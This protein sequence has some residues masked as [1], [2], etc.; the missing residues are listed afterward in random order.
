MYLALEKIHCTCALQVKALKAVQNSGGRS[1]KERSETRFC[2]AV[3]PGP[4]WTAQDIELICN[5]IS[6]AMSI[7]CHLGSSGLCALEPLKFCAQWLL[8]QFAA[9]KCTLRKQPFVYL[10]F[11]ASE[12]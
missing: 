3:A 8:E 10:A 4:I 6:K 9:V 11:N 7:H 5:P 1:L 2:S 12:I